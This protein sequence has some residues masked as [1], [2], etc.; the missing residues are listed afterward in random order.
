MIH[1]LILIGAILFQSLSAD[2][3]EEVFT[4]IYKEGSWGKNEEGEGYSGPGSEPKHAGPYIAF[5][6]HFIKSNG[7]KSVVD[8]GCGDWSFSK[9]IDWG[10]IQYE[11]IDIVKS[12][13]EKNKEQFASPTITFTHADFL[14]DPLPEGDLL[15]CKDVLQH[16]SNQEIDHFLQKISQFKHVLITND[17]DPNTLTGT[18]FDIKAGAWRTL[19]LNKPP[20]NCYGTKA[21]TY[22]ADRATKQILHIN[23]LP[24]NKTV[25]L[26]I[27]ARNKEHT[28]PEFLKCIENLD[29]N[30]KLIGIYINTNNNTDD[31]LPMLLDWIAKNQDSYRFITFE[32]QNVQETLPEAPYEWNPLRFSVLG[33]IRNKSLQ[34]AKEFGMDYYFVV[35]C[36]NF[37]TP[38][39]L[40]ELVRK[41]KPIIAPMLRSIPEQNDPYSNFFT[42]IDKNGYYAEEPSYYFILYRS[43]SGTFRVPVVHCTYLIKSEYIDKLNYLDQTNDFEF[44][45][46]SRGARNNDIGQYICNEQDFGSLV[47][48]SI[49]PPT[50]K[51]EQ[52]RIADFFNTSNPPTEVR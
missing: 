41:D 49:Y 38:C 19:D 9:Y 50:L 8:V 17:I 52:E 30:K 45:I 34:K 31:T 25:L 14:N 4:Q 33:K 40:K 1:F 20:F 46:F 15:I 10:E 35:D 48:F 27:L 42:A 28:L 23:N 39:T 16:L 51:E 2:S 36:D 18:N 24:E 29:Y 47:H 22:Q 5:L 32:T 43:I 7:I 3:N 6:Q 12:V 11:G 37:I 26:A 44:V 13:I 21:L